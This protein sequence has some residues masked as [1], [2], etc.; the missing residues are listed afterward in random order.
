MTNTTSSRYTD[1]GMEKAMQAAA[2]AEIY[3]MSC[4][5]RDGELGPVQDEYLSLHA[6]RAGALAA[7]VKHIANAAPAGVYADHETGPSAEML[8][9][10]AAAGAL[11]LD[12][13]SDGDTA[14]VLA[15][16]DTAD[17]LCVD[18][19]NESTG[20]FLAIGIHRDTVKP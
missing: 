9:T 4:T 2:G 14:V 20:L 3:R 7:A 10:L 18:L 12:L 13:K 19:G 11:K 17:Q 6:S 1:T 15:A 16:D 8:K 5:V